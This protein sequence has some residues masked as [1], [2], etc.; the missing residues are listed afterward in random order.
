MPYV[1]GAA[2]LANIAKVDA[3]LVAVAKLAIT[4]TTQDF[5]FTEPQ[6]RTVAEEAQKMS[7]G[8]SKTLHTHHLINDGKGSTAWEPTPPAVDFCAALDAVPWDGSKFVWEWPLIYPI[9]AA[10]RQASI[11][12]GTPI[13]W[14]GVWDKLMTQYG[15]TAAE[16]EAE[17]QAYTARQ[18]AAGNHHVLLDGP[19]YE[20]GRN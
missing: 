20:L 15:G 3:R 19:H 14:G 8:H 1:L 17:V 12:L 13:T 10:F 16:L 9:A 11:T 2:S 4:L 6:W 7:E 18:N 5:G